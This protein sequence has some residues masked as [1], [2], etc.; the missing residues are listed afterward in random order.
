[1]SS[2][3]VLDKLR[4][5]R[6]QSRDAAIAMASQEDFDKESDAYQALEQRA[7][8]LDSQIEQLTGLMAAR[9]AADALDG[10]LSKASQRQQEERGQQ[11]IQTQQSWGEAWTRSDEFTS[12]RMKGSSGVL[13]IEDRPQ[14]RALPT[15]ISDLVS[16]GLK[17]APYQTSATAPTPPTPLLNAVTNVQVSGNS[18]EV[19]SWAKVAGGAAIVAEKAAKPSAEFKPTVVPGVLDLVAVY[20]QL[21]RA[22]MEDF[23]AVTS[24]IDQ[25]LRRDVARKEEAEAAAA[26][27]AATLPTAEGADLV[28]A[29][30]VGVGVVQ[31][32]GYSPNAVL[33]NPADYAAADIAVMGAT[34]LGP[35][36]RQNYWGLT[37]IPAMSQPEGTATVG[38]FAAGVQHLYRSQISLFVTDSHADTFLTN[39]FTL[40]AERRSKTLVVKPQALVEVS[41]S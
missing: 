14:E 6:D 4:S 13:T 31:A 41:A 9:E 35:Q 28:S 40:L 30:R 2:T 12:Y 36:V 21:T 3:L 7:L 22:M 29:I 27:T 20:T 16:A 18:Y 5:E 39:V 34:L 10:R 23:S 25:E 38:D 1:M 8:S 37:P 33:L 11:G 19:I 17:G 32:E 15:G 24:L 26:L